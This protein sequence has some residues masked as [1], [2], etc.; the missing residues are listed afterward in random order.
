MKRKI[1]RYRVL[2]GLLI[3]VV[4]SAF[5]PGKNI[6]SPFY[7]E[8]IRHAIMD[9]R[10]DFTADH[11]QPSYGRS[12]TI[13]GSYFVQCRKDTLIVSLPYYGK[14]NSAA[15]ATNDNPLDF[16]STN[17]K[18][19]KQEKK[20]GKW[21]VTVKPENSEVQSMSFTF[22][23]NGSAQVNFIMTNRSGINFSGKVSPPKRPA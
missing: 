16:K 21:L 23:D 4:A 1:N 2:I 17:S 15:G 13:M 7:Q 14:L 3:S 22:F 12:R 19:E 9:D 8:D 11:A 5:F 10:W 20:K 6:R 18:I